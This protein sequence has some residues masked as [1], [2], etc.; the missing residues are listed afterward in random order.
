[1]VG[2]RQI[3]IEHPASVSL[4][5]MMRDRC[6]YKWGTEMLSFHPPHPR[7]QQYLEMY[8]NAEDPFL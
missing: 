3:K 2:V 1:M 5:G 4:M 8:Q 6:V 7:K